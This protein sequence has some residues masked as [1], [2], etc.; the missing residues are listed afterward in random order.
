MVDFISSI[1][2]MTAKAITNNNI[3]H[4]FGANEM[5]DDKF[6]TFPDLKKNTV[7]MSGKSY[8]N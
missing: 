1:P 5:I 4:G 6:E 8:R 7:S 2:K 3:I